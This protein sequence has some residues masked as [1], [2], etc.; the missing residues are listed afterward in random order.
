[1]QKLQNRAARVVTSSSIDA[2]S[3]PL[4]NELDCKTIDELVNESKVMVYRSQHQFSLQ[5]LSSMFIKK[6]KSLLKEPSQYWDRFE[7]P[8]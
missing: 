8:Y 5:H 1:L 3:R 7:A 4:V 6:L 2:P